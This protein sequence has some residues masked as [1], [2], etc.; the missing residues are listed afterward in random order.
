MTHR[1]NTRPIIT[2]SIERAFA[3]RVLSPEESVGAR[4]LDG[5][6][7]GYYHRP[8]KGEL[9]RQRWVVYVK[10]GGHCYDAQSCLQ[11]SDT[12]YGSST[13][14]PKTFGLDGILSNNSLVN[15]LFSNWTHALLWYCSADSWAGNRTDAYYATDPSD[16]QRQ[17]G[18]Y[19]QGFRVV[20]AL[21]NALV[22]DQD[23]G[24]ARELLL[25]GD[26]AAGTGMAL[27]ADSLPIW[28]PW[29]QKVRLVFASAYF[30]H[31]P[32]QDPARVDEDVEMWHSKIS[33]PIQPP[34]LRSNWVD[35]ARY[36]RPE[37]RPE[38]S[39]N[40]QPWMADVSEL[41][42]PMVALP[43]FL[44]QS[45]LDSC[46]LDEF[47]R[48]VNGTMSTAPGGCL[49]RGSQ[50]LGGCSALEASRLSLHRSRV[51]S[52][53]NSSRKLGGS[54]SGG[55]LHTCLG[56][57]D[58]LRKNR[59]YQQTTIDG[60]S[61]Q[62]ALQSWWLD[63]SGPG[64]NAGVGHWHMPC[65]LR[66]QHPYQCNPSCQAWSRQGPSP[67]AVVSLDEPRTSTLAAS[68]GINQPNGPEVWLPA[69]LSVIFPVVL[70][71]LMPL[72]LGRVALRYAA[73]AAASASNGR[74]RLE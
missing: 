23:F 45:T 63:G 3:G 9:G 21:L 54:S 61:L 43:I 25:V 50:D 8:G 55:F 34:A 68:H 17:M 2:D 71:V 51:M 15:P 42:Y 19:F 1:L 20:R 6:P 72:A 41:L 57:A 22:R 30:L 44:V 53:L 27:W 18:L 4:C 28:F 52:A 69:V 24:S 56:H 16:P 37:L 47:W 46:V 10:G 62:R 12:P 26:C 48:G 33:T 60:V 32:N 40:F 11:A 5:S 13:R 65:E 7:P 49:D 29:L 36:L 14:F 35:E 39:G 70:L 74:S 64:G 59:V 58:G 31:L 67:P 73:A 38:L 66:T